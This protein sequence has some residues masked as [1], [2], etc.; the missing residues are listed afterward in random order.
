[1][2]KELNEFEYAIIE[3]NAK[4]YLPLIDKVIRIATDVNLEIDLADV[5][6]EEASILVLDNTVWYTLYGD[7]G[8]RRSIAILRESDYE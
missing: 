5:G 1:M 3:D 6:D 2:Y 7:Q 8:E 4:Q